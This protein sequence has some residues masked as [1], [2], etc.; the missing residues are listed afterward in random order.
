MHEDC[1]S[2]Q[3]DSEVASFGPANVAA[4]HFLVVRVLSRAVVRFR[5]LV[6]DCTGCGRFSS[7]WVRSARAI[8]SVGELVC[9]SPRYVAWN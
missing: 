9:C 8:R 4:V 3:V 6:V 2:V 5:L 7:V 1:E